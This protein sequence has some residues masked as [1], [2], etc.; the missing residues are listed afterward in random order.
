MEL[1]ALSRINSK[2]EAQNASL[3]LVSPQLVKH[4]R[5][6]T[7]EKKLSVPILSD[8]GNDVAARYGLRW[9]VP[10]DLKAIYQKFGIDLPNHNGDES[11]TLP[12]PARL[13]IDQERIVRYAE[14]SVDYTM[15]PDP[16]ETLFALRELRCANPE[17]R[18]CAV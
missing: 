12:V 5:E 18:V 7:K 13:I 17:K 2:F 11:W 8:P 15:R 4:N 3:T 16:E 14:I 10:P 9:K 1:E 6:F